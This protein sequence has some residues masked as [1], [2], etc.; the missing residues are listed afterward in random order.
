MHCI[1]RQIT[2]KKERLLGQILQELG[3]VNRRKKNGLRR[4]SKVMNKIKEWLQIIQN[5]MK[6]R[7]EWTDGSC[8]VGCLVIGLS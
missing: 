2:E 7:P 3:N 5:V 6:E 8:A 4:I 1:L